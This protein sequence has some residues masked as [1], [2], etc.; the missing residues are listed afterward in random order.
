M[1]KHR[2]VFSTDPELTKCT[3]C[4]CLE[5][6]CKA[7]APVDQG[8]LKP[9]LRLE[10]KGRKGKSVTIIANL[11][12]NISFLKDLIK[13]L[14]TKCGTGGTCRPDNGIIEIQGDKREMIRKILT[15]K[16][17]NVRGG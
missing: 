2:L 17:M 13:E 6:E 1:A 11:P 12:E 15:D 7:P 8:K 3:M 4:G 5:C 9:F 16:G 14:K 10:K